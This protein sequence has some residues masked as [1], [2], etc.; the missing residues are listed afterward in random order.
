[1]GECALNA[2]GPVPVEG[3]YEISNEVLGSVKGSNLPD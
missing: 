1:M 3:Y 2:L